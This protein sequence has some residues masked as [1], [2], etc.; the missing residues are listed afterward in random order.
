MSTGRGEEVWRPAR[1]PPETPGQFFRRHQPRAASA[2]SSGTASFDRFRGP[3]GTLRAPPQPVGRTDRRL[4]RRP[5][6]A[7][8]DPDPGRDC[9]TTSSPSGAPSRSCSP[10][11]RSITPAASTGSD[12]PPVATPLARFVALSRRR[13]HRESTAPAC[14]CSIVAGEALKDLAAGRQRPA[15]TCQRR[16]GQ[17][18]E[19]RGRKPRPNFGG[20]RVAFEIDCPAAPMSV[21]LR[22][23]LLLNGDTRL[24]ETWLYRWTA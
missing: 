18:R 22:L 15:W 24:S 13:R 6:P 3:R 17:G 1:Q 4:G 11:P 14:S 19:R 12:L 7:A 8:R 2:W 21:E 16:Q 20:W 23:V 10:R 9:T 5:G